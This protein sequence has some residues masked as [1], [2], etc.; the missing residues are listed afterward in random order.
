[1]AT[2][3]QLP[4]VINGISS[5]NIEEA[6]PDK[7]EPGTI[8]PKK[9]PRRRRGPR[10]YQVHQEE[11]LAPYNKFRILYHERKFQRPVVSQCC[12]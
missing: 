5:P 9:K 10:P 11:D 1:M 6:V 8:E 7:A 12:F 4:D 2:Y 3:H